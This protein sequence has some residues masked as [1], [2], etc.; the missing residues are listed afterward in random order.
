MSRTEEVKIL[1]VEDNPGDVQIITGMVEEMGYPVELTIAVDGREAIN[2]LRRVTL[3]DLPDLVILDLNLPKVHG[4]EILAMIRSTPC[5]KEL[6]VVVM[7]GSLNPDDEVRSRRLGATDY[8]IK[9]ATIDEMDLIAVV[10]RNHIEAVSRSK[11]SR[12]APGPIASPGQGPLRM[13][14]GRSRRPHGMDGPRF[15]WND[16]AAVP[17]GNGRFIG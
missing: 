11:G 10:L 13:D 14:D 4:Y 15:V 12:R 2:R 7:T 16:P 17:P 3:H 1:I 5:L 9:P 6:P 8:R